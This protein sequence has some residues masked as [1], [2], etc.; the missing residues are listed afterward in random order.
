MSNE[1]RFGSLTTYEKYQDHLSQLMLAGKRE[2]VVAISALYDIITQSAI[3]TET[4]K[5]PRVDTL[6][7]AAINPPPKLVQEAGGR[8]KVAK[9]IA[10]QLLL[11]N[12]NKL[13]LA[14]KA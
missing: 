10:T 3:I 7:Q 6:I 13:Q 11:S 2:N 14:K 12:A 5:D 9:Y 8:E 1:V 4:Y